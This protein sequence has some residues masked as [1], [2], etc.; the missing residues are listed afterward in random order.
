MKIDTRQISAQAIR[1]AIEQYPKESCGLIVDGRYVP[2]R[3]DA[4][5]KAN[6]PQNN[7]EN[8]FILNRE[9]YR[10]AL[11]SGEVQA[12]IHSHCD[13]PAKASEADLQ[14][15]VESDLPWGIIEVRD[16]NYAGHEWYFPDQIDEAPLLGRRFYH[17]VHDCLSMVLDYYKREMGVDLGTYE[18]EDD[19]WNQGKDY[20]RE[21][22][23]KAGFEKIDPAVDGYKTGD[24]IL[25]QI[26]SPVPNHAGIF[27]EDGM[28]RSETCAHPAACVI[29]HHMYG[30][31]SRRDLY[32]GYYQQKTVSVWRWRKPQARLSSSGEA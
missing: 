23:P 4:P 32:G 7:S 8:H 22:L 28:L 27:L 18:R 21:L 29:L 15:C 31:L 10:V 5:D 26:R 16:G 3:N 20:Y 25:M 9:D 14:M 12:V 24:I 11:E 2:C 19:W 6:D 30:Q 1:H 17:G 13:W